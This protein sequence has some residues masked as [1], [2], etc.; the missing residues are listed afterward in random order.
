M[1]NKQENPLESLL[2]RIAELEG[3]FT[4]LQRTVQDLDQVVFQQHRRLDVLD[5]RLARLS[6][7]LEA[8]A[9]P[10]APPTELEDE[11]PPHY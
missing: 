11:R 2:D 5:A 4:H 7:S 1:A 6:A 8:M 10:Q 9:A 3:L